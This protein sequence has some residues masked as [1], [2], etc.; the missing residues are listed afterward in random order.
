M[1]GSYHGQKPSKR[2]IMLDLE[3]PAITQI[4]A[5]KPRAWYIPYEN[6]Q[7]P[8]PH[9]PVD[10]SRLSTLNGKWDFC[11]LESPLALPE[12][13]TADFPEHE[14]RDSIQVPG[15]W[16][17]MGHDRP[18]YLNLM[19]PFPVNPPFIPRKNPVGVYRREVIIPRHWQDQEI[20]L[21]FLGVSSAYEVYL[22]GQFVGA[23]KG[24]H[25]THEFCITSL[26]SKDQTNVFTVIV[27]KWC[28]GAYLEDQDMWRLH[29]IFR[30]V[31]LTARPLAHLHDIEIKTDFDAKNFRAEL[32]V[33]FATNNGSTLPL[34]AILKDPSGE[35]IFSLEISSNKTLKKSFANVQPWTTETPTLYALF[36][37]TLSED[38]QTTEVIGFNIGFRRISIRDQQFLVNERPITI[39]GVN[40]H[41][42]DP[43]TGWTVSKERMEQDARLMKQHNINTVR[44][45]HYINHPYWYHLCNTLGLYI[46]DEADLE[47]H[48]FQITG[49]WSELSDNDQWEAAYLNR[50]I[51]MVERDKNYPC[52][53]MWSLGNE[54]GYGKNH[55]RM[56]EWI[57]TRD[58]S[59]P[60]HY[61]GAGDA[62]L[63][64]VISVMYPTVKTLEVAG[65]NDFNDPRPFFMCEYAHTMGNSPGSLREFWETIRRY[66]RLIG[67][68]V[69][70]W[71]DQ[72]L[73]TKTIQGET[74]FFYGG[75]FGVVPN[76]GNFCI[77]GLVNPD[78]K[79]HPALEELKFWHQ[80]VS[81]RSLYLEHQ[82]L[83]IENRYDFINLDHLTAKYQIK[84]DGVTL[85]NKHL[86]LPE[87]GPGESAAIIIPELLNQISDGKEYWIEVE[88]R[89]KEKTN[90]G[91]K[92]HLIAHNQE[93]VQTKQKIYLTSHKHSEKSIKIMSNNKSSIRVAIGDRQELLFNKNSGWIDQW[94]VDGQDVLV[95]PLA[96][97]I[98]RAPIDNDI[99][100]AKEWVV[101]GLDRTIANPESILV[102]EA[103]NEIEVLVDGSLAADGYKPHSRYT[104]QYCILDKGVINIRLDFYPLN[105]LTRLPRLGFKSR[106]N[107][108]YD[109]VCWFGRGPH[110]SY[111]DRRDSAFVD[112]YEVNINDLFHFYLNPQENGNRSDI[113]WLN[114]ISPNLPKLCVESNQNFNFNLHHYS[115]DNLTQAKHW[116]ELNR[117]TDPSLY[118]DMAHSG[119]GS[120]ACGPDTLP[121]YQ[122][123]PK[124]YSFSFFTFLE[125]D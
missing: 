40:R 89:L 121:E 37:E 20:I 22:N 36:F 102:N 54:S 95:A 25:L 4:N 100:I 70:D 68:C 38:G 76:D 67:G 99:H 19:Y 8:I 3:N 47:T 42:F 23:A 90:W 103:H 75:D 96:L 113:R 98:W 2:S 5:M 44:T 53:I 91:T 85:T 27:Y 110:E 61:E 41:E 6:P 32:E 119:L 125:N 124:H 55:D 93:Q 14:M 106:I 49:N 21:T 45:S 52:I 111:P 83:V 122:L 87:I 82:T 94:S 105:L 101:D 77:N 12:E 86:L 13:L 11:L 57:K 69:W 59:R 80:P 66:P 51:R 92:G 74:T 56:S 71:V 81:L 9:Y 28:D 10:S 46:I 39:K 63:V 17:C 31:Y 112:R 16:E 64:D 18:Q 108:S 34:R 84:S 33:N 118:I 123:S 117:E 116:H 65:K 43:D 62:A 79:P 35:D 120:N 7:T 58:G 78:R 24:S 1:I 73:R 109:K 30:D 15:C 88:F 26:L 60:I 72:G 107:S 104:L 50:A 48:G 115:Q 114:I 97:N 29:G